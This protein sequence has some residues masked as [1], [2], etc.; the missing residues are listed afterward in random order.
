MAPV[1]SRTSLGVV[2]AAEHLAR[3]RGRR[4]RRGRRSRR[5]GSRGAGERWAAWSRPTASASV[6]T[7][8]IGRQICPSRRSRVKI[9]R[10]TVRSIDQAAAATNTRTDSDPEPGQRLELEDER[11]R[12]HHADASI[13]EALTIRRS[14]SVGRSTARAWYSLFSENE[15]IQTGNVMKASTRC[16]ALDAE[17]G[18]RTARAHCQTK[19]SDDAQRRRRGRR[20]RSAAACSVEGATELVDCHRFR[21]LQIDVRRRTTARHAARCLQFPP[22]LRSEPN[23]TSAQLQ[24]DCDL[25]VQVRLCPIVTIGRVRRRDDA[26]IG[27]ASRSVSDGSPATPA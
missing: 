21:R 9:R 6:P 3:R 11:Q 14:S 4:C 10:A 18:R 19:A 16:D 23:P 2:D 22:V 15:T 26:S 5:P 12:D 17:L 24:C 1:A 7:I 27:I 13:S 20:R 8:R 25:A